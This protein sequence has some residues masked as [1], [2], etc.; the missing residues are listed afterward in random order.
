MLSDSSKSAFKIASEEP[1][2]ILLKSTKKTWNCPAFLAISDPEAL[3]IYPTKILRPPF[4]RQFFLS[5][6]FY[7]GHKTPRALKTWE[8]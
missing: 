2:K 3:T 8:N 5:L 6:N 1:Q 4:N 7:F